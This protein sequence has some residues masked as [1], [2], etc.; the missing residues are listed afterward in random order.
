MRELLGLA[1]EEAQ[2]LWEDLT[3]GYTEAD[4]S[5]LLRT[6]V[7]KQYQRVG[8]DHVTVTIGAQEALYLLTQVLIAP[9]DHAVVITPAYQILYDG[10]RAA[11]GDVTLVPLKLESRW[12]LDV[13]S[14]AEALRAETKLLVINFPH[15]PT[16]SLPTVDQYL[17]LLNLCH[18][19]GVRVISDE[20]F[21]GME[22]S[23]QDRLPAAA[24]VVSSAVSVGDLSKS[25][26][27]AGLRV[28]WVACRDQA[29]LERIAIGRD[30]TTIS[31]CGPSH[32]LALIA[33]RARAILHER[34]RAIVAGNLAL[35]SD[36]FDSRR[37]RVEWLVPKA[38]TTAF[39]RLTRGDVE[40]FCE[41]LGS[42]EGVLLAP[43]S[44]FET[45][46]GH[47]RLGLAH[48]EMKHGLKA[49]GHV[50]STLR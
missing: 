28:G 9:G 1:D 3:L 35:V 8:P 19:K 4:G 27:L 38:G 32:V 50:L 25:Y 7:A 37:D 22:R 2:R 33:L 49:I 41:R 30:Y 16:G 42:E 45:G 46:G 44:T 39:P 24:D 12:Q 11:G 23:P 21:R 47:F 36:F 14:I 29:V 5:E 31:G 15:N 10:I 6:E 43:G 18:S 20:V 34:A 40:E 26:G 48:R 13:A 17:R